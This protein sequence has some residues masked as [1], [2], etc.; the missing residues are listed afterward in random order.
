MKR[1]VVIVRLELDLIDC[2]RRVCRRDQT[3][4]V[5]QVEVCDADRSRQA[6]LAGLQHLIPNELAQ[7]WAT[8]RRFWAAAFAIAGSNT[9]HV[10]E[11]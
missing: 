10:H 4:Q 6:Q 8:R 1:I 7:L 5:A 9:G 2:R 3:L 11:I